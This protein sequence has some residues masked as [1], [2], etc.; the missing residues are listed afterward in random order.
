MQQELLLRESYITL[1]IDVPSSYEI[2]RT[3]T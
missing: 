2:F 3:I 1:D